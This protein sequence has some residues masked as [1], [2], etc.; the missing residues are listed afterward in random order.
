MRRLQLQ[1]KVARADQLFDFDFSVVVVLF[2]QDV[3]KIKLLLKQNTKIQQTVY[4]I[5]LMQPLSQ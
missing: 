2:A 4:Y 5:R 3:D 1:V